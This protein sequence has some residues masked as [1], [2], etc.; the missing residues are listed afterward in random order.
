MC[1]WCSQSL[2][3]NDTQAPPH[4]A[5]WRRSRRGR[6]VGS[7]AGGDVLAV[8]PGADAVVVPAGAAAANVEGDAVPEAVVAC[9]G[10]RGRRQSEG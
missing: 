1:R 10:W 3:L 8:A 4:P 2:R 5:A 9:H 6:E 7:S